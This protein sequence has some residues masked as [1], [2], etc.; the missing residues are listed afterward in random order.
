VGTHCNNCTATRPNQ[1]K[2][3]TPKN[4]DI[5]ET[6][7]NENTDGKIGLTVATVAV[8]VV[9]VVCVVVV[10]KKNIGY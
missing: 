10:L 3:E 6:P 5:P 7:T 8:F 4:N 9:V 1:S 2:A